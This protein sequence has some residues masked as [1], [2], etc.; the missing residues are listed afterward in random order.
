[1]GLSICLR[2]QRLFLRFFVLSLS[3]TLTLTITLWI[4]LNPNLKSSELMPKLNRKHFEI[5]GL[6]Q[7]SNSDMRLWE[8]VVHLSHDVQWK[9]VYVSQTR[10]PTTKGQRSSQTVMK[11]TEVLENV[12][13]YVT[14]P[15]CNNMYHLTVA[16]LSCFSTQKCTLT[17]I[18]M[19]M[20]PH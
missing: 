19:I 15:Y 16:V 9:E 13:I 5:W 18:K 12:F 17:P 4:K 3:Q 14:M 7:Q 6:Q 11:E 10:L 8:L 1:M 20:T 2:F